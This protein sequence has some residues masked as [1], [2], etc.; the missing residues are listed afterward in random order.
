MV[1]EADAEHPSADV[2]TTVY[3]VVAAGLAVTTEPVAAERP[4]DGLH[5]YVLAP[6]AV[7]LRLPPGK[8]VADDGNTPTAGIAFTVIV[9][10][11]ENAEVTA[12]L[13]FLL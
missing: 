3:V 1:M 7:T 5:E 8:M 12:S 10:T 9:I 13:T 11:L 4:V 2:P 6:K